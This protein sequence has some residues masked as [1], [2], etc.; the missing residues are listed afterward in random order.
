MFAVAACSRPEITVV[1]D[2]GSSLYELRVIAEQDSQAEVLGRLD[3]LPHSSE[4]VIVI[5]RD[6]GRRSNGLLIEASILGY[7]PVTAHVKLEGSRQAFLP[8]AVIGNDVVA[9]LG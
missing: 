7:H 4:H 8:V 1:N 9:S 2:C 6:T 5:R 3:V